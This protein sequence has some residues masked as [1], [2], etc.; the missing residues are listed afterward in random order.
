MNNESVVAKSSPT[1][2]T[3]AVLEDEQMLRE[4]LCEMLQQY[5]Y[6]VLDAGLGQT[7]LDEM[8]SYPGKVDLILA[9]VRMPE[10]SGPQIVSLLREGQQASRWKQSKVLY[11]SGYP[12]EDAFKQGEEFNFLSKPYS[13]N[14]LLEKI[15]EIL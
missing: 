8:S 13:R 2:Q 11:V 4:L 6:K 12:P 1:K 7:A 5:G 14:M 9:D 10:L 3:I 15:K